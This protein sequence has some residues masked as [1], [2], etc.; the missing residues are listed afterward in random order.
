M[1]LPRKVD[2]QMKYL[3]QR[4]NQIAPWGTCNCTCVAMCMAKAGIV[5][6]GS[7]PQLEDQLTQKMLKEGWNRQN[8]YHLQH[9]FTWKKVPSMFD[10][11]ATVEQVKQHLASGKPCITHGWFTP[12]GHII[13]LKGYDDAAYNGRGAWICHDPNGEWN[14]DGYSHQQGAGESVLYSYQM[15]RETCQ[16]GGQFWVHFC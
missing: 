15:I 7:L 11:K 6:D 13:V 1:Q 8:P 14:A 12:S 9:L 10:P 3:S 5:G 16:T 4:D 2:I